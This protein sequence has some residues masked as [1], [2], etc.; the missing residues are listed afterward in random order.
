MEWSPAGNYFVLGCLGAEGT[1]LFCFL[2]DNDKVEVIHKDE[3]FMVNSI[4]WSS[5]GRY[6]STCVC[7]PMPSLGGPASTAT[8]RFSAEAG[9]CIWGFQGKLM[10]KVK[11]EGLYS[12]D[13]RP[14]PPSLLPREEIE[15][16]KKNIKTYSKRY[17]AIDEQARTEQKNACRAKRQANIDSFKQIINSLLEW[18]AQD[19]CYNF[20]VGTVPGIRK[21]LGFI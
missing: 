5:C 12:F 11:K 17:D 3:H 1:L 21:C 13:F 7:V 4:R 15:K 6:V 10:Y 9:Y 19:V 20:N 16:I 8:F 2:N 14:H 18:H